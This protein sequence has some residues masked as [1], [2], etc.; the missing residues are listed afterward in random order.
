VKRTAVRAKSAPAPEKPAEPPEK[1]DTAPKVNAEG[2]PVIRQCAAPFGLNVGSRGVALTTEGAVFFSARRIDDLP[3]SAFAAPLNESLKAV[4]KLKL[5]RLVPWDSI[6][7]LKVRRA[8]ESAFFD[9]RADGKKIQWNVPLAQSRE[10]VDGCARSLGGRFESVL[11]PDDFAVQPSKKRRW[12]ILSCGLVLVAGVAVF[13][14]MNFARPLT[15]TPSPP[16]A[17]RKSSEPEALTV[18]Q[19]LARHAEVAIPGPAADAPYTVR[20]SPGWK[21]DIDPEGGATFTFQKEPEVVV[22]VNVL[23][24]T[25]SDPEPDI[26]AARSA[27]ETLVYGAKPDDADEWTWLQ[28]QQAERPI[29]QAPP[30]TRDGR[31]WTPFEVADAKNQRTWRA[32]FTAGQGCGYLIFGHSPVPDVNGK[33]RALLE[34]AFYDFSVPALSPDE[35]RKR[36]E[37]RIA[38]Y[39]DSLFD[40]KAV[41]SKGEDPAFLVALG[42]GWRELPLEGEDRQFLMDNNSALSFQVYSSVP[43]VSISEARQVFRNRIGCKDRPDWPITESIVTKPDGKAWRD[44]RAETDF[45]GVHMHWH[46]QWCGDLEHTYMLISRRWDQTPELDKLANQ[47]LDQAF[48]NFS[49]APLKTKEYQGGARPY[50]FE[51]PGQWTPLDLSANG[52]DKA[53]QGP[54]ELVLRVETGAGKYTAENLPALVSAARANFAKTYRLGPPTE[55]GRWVRFRADIDIADRS[56]ACTFSLTVTPDAYYM[57]SVVVPLSNL[58]RCEPVMGDILDAIKLP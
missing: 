27:F 2:L 4:P 13:S 51:L 21:S 38:V 30:V 23:R 18:D 1:L 41:V 56:Y 53:W 49:R 32:E 14:W 47:L 44:W 57:V 31:L 25:D 12:I 28:T 10:M 15:A 55:H 9:A 48:A 45:H 16:K 43:L 20:L 33:M 40:P 5:K 7:D 34:K 3:T 58:E 29:T 6:T 52:F 17:V 24:K 37:A 36:S 46:G 8:G 39:R 50:V 35:Q 42:K 26:G 11:N 19:A 54:A 22:G